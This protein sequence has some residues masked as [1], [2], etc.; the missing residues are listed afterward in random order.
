MHGA[1]SVPVALRARGIHK[2]FPGVRALHDVDFEIRAGEVHGLVGENGAGK[3]TLVRI[4]TGADHA[5][6]GRVEVFGHALRGAD[7]RSA[8][9]A[10]VGA[11]YQDLA[12]VPEL[13]A[14][15]NVFLGR[16]PRRGHT[17]SRR[18]MRQAFGRLADQLGARI[19]PDARAGSLSVANQ[20]MLRIMGSLAADLRVLVMDEPTASL[21][22]AEREALYETIRRL[23]ASTVAVVYVSHNLDEVLEL[24]DRVSVMRDG[25]L[26]ATQPAPRWTK[27]TLVTAILG[28]VL[29]TPTPRRRA[30]T[31]EEA[32]RVEGLEVPGVLSDVSFTLRR[33]EVLGLG[34]LV[35]SGRSELLRSL[36]GADPSA[37][38]RLFV[39]GRERSLPRTVRRA[40]AM[41]I[42][43]APGERK[44]EGLLLSLSAAANVCLTDMQAVAVGPV[45]RESRQLERAEEIMGPLGFGTRRLIEAADSFSGGNQ[46]KL[47]IGK[48]LHRRPDVLLMDEFMRGIDVG[49]KAEMLDVVQGLAADGMSI[50]VVSSELED[51][52]EAADRV[53]VLA[54]RRVIG[55]LDRAEASVERILRLVFASA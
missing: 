53:L 5:D 4:M 42:A 40:L 8:Q 22:H 35:G 24:C 34:G 15:V 18:M 14:A 44:S 16:P 54:R 33:G 51:L 55:E 23:Q 29:R 26:V 6:A 28:R 9:R 49:A 12:V 7:R 37:G 39:N 3:S 10:G 48:W 31:E 2:S 36:A 11:I 21:G 32:L 45:L 30:I 52:V 38:G 1:G 19:D 27:Q 50:I 25:E 20:Q 43:L 13:S 47:V 17:V 41:G 46:Q